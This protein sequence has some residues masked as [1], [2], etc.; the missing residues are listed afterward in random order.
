MAV[1]TTPLG[2]KYVADI[3]LLKEPVREGRGEL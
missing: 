3:W 2:V 1:I